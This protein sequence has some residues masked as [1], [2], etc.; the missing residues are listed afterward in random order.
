MMAVNIS[1]YVEIGRKMREIPPEKPFASYEWEELVQKLCLSDDAR[2]HEIG[3][4]EL[5]ILRQKCPNCPAFK[6]C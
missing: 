4:R 5:D 6:N 2:L 3:V 1:K